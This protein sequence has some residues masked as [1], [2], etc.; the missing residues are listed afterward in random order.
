M[1]YDYFSSNSN[2]LAK[3]QRIFAI[4]LVEM[5]AQIMVS[6][7]PGHPGRE[8]PSYPGQHSLLPCLEVV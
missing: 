7:S 4:F 8:M 5:V 2:E 6:H 3:H 1:L